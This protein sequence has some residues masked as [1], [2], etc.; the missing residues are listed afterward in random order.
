M[1]QVLP[2]LFGNLEGETLRVLESKM[3]WVHLARGA[4]LF[5]QG[6]PSDSFYVIISGRL[7]TIIDDRRG[8][9]QMV[10]ELSQGESVGEMGVF[11]GDPRSATLI[12][13]RDTELVQFSKADFHGFVVQYPLVMQRVTQLLIQ[14]LNRTYRRASSSSLS[15]N[16]LLAPAC[17][18]VPLDEFSQ[19]FFGALSK[20]DSCL[21]LSSRRIDELLETPGMSQAMDG[22]P[23]DLRLRT[24]LNEQ[25]KIS[26]HRL[27]VGLGR[28]SLDSSLYPPG[29][30]DHLCGSSLGSV[31]CDRRRT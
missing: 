23:N 5:E 11:T 25:E 16:I 1:V 20:L 17:L 22:G 10:G 2:V 12:A 28:H 21:L 6:T 24:W 19:Q 13:S 4:T 8:H 9:R 30:R 31:R 18:G 7:Q 15:S 26:L 3:N 14:R 27:S 29:R